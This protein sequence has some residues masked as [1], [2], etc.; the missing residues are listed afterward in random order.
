MSGKAFDTFQD[1]EQGGLIVN[2]SANVCELVP[3]MQL[4]VM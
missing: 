3:L 1:V 2:T 4:T